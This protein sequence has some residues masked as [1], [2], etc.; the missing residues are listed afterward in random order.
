MQ[1]SAKYMTERQW[2]AVLNKAASKQQNLRLTMCLSGTNEP[3]DNYCKN[4]LV[5]GNVIVFILFIIHSVR[6][7]RGAQGPSCHL[8]HI[9]IFSG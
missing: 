1:I 3:K 7:S 9:C 2:D 4:Q 6:V 5:C 8:V